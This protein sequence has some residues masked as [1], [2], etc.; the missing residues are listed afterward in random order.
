MPSWRL[1][2]AV[3]TTALLLTTGCADD[4]SSTDRGRRDGQHAGKPTR[5]AFD[6]PRRFAQHA[7]YYAQ[8]EEYAV[9]GDAVAV[10]PTDG[11][12]HSRRA[13]EVRGADGKK[14]HTLPLPF[15]ESSYAL[16]GL[17]TDK[18]QVLLLTGER[19]R[20]GTGTQRDR[21]QDTVVAH[22]V[23]TGRRL[24]Q[25]VMDTHLGT[26]RSY[27]TIVAANDRAV[28]VGD[29]G[30]HGEQWLAVLDPATGRVRWQ[31]DDTEPVGLD[32]GRV[33]GYRAGRLVALDVADG[34]QRWRG[35]RLHGTVSHQ[36][37]DVD[38]TGV[39]AVEERLEADPLSE[40]KVRVHLVDT[41]TGRTL[42]RLDHSWTCLADR[43]PVAVCEQDPEGDEETPPALAAYDTRSGEEL[44]RID[45]ST[46][47][48]VVPR[49]LDVRGKLVYA[50]TPDTTVTLDLR[51]GKDRDT[52]LG[53][54]EFQ[55][56]GPGFAVVYDSD[57][58]VVFP[59]TR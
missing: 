59:A 16:Y 24:W 36:H 12:S 58:I 30:M 9:V 56:V 42:R 54:E 14:R 50:A 53:I 22:D 31:Q 41:A 21:A 48:R 47:D 23:T 8:I 25:R 57:M 32:G 18:R 10:V 37:H 43:A 1:P 34:T 3:L 38:G 52:N 15:P 7:S 6:P 20:H 55:H 28:L 29:D 40:D 39:V 11:T 51:T 17:T 19:V 33:L 49:L 5:P 46:P 45:D 2:L 35:P 13:V 4:G 27:P 26:D 44:W